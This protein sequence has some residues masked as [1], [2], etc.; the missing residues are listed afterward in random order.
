MGGSIIS[1]YVQG[2]EAGRL[3]KDVIDNKD[4]DYSGYFKDGETKYM[5]DYNELKKFDIPKSSLPEGSVIINSPVNLID[6]YQTEILFFTYIIVGILIINI[7][8][9]KKNEK[10]LIAMVNEKTFHLEKANHELKRLSNVDGLTQLYNR[11]YF[12]I[13][14]ENRWKEFQRN[15]LP[16]SL[17]M[18]D[19][20]FFKRYNDIYGHIAGDNC[21]KNLSRVFFKSVGRPFDT[22]ARYGG[23]EF[24]VL[25]NTD[26]QGAEKIAQ[27]I[28]EEVEKLEI[29]HEG[30][31]RGLVTVSIGI[32][33]AVPIED[34]GAENLLEISDQALYE[35]KNKGRNRSTL[36]YLEI[37][38]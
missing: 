17:L 1:G 6:K 5:F 31:A 37:K 34:F 15:G 30:S 23:E 35:S 9:N 16:L 33:V 8:L 18:I 14:L 28:L 4:K 32:G 7:F 36:K 24:T 12:D 25:V 3:L 29:P 19:V 11:R 20:D 2:L 22:V 27:W 26:A 38:Q 21:L 10:K 13:N